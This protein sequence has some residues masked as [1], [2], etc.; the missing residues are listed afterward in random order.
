LDCILDIL[1][2]FRNKLFIMAI[3]KSI[4][5]AAAL[6]VSVVDAAA[7]EPRESKLVSSV[8]EHSTY[9]TYY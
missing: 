4:A 6:A 2:N 3:W 1:T 7:I 5:V 9:G 8:S